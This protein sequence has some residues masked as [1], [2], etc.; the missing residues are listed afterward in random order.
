MTFLVTWAIS[1]SLPVQTH[2][3]LQPQPTGPADTWE[4]V[5]GD[6][7]GLW[8]RPAQS[9]QQA[10]THGTQ[11]QS[12]DLSPAGQGGRSMWPATL[13][14]LSGL[15]EGWPQDYKNQTNLERPHLQ[16]GDSIC[17]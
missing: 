12:Q 9:S 4:T 13:G 17:T 7:D 14:P 10:T 5:A 1:H 15:G 16:D 2:F 3:Q 11:R 8:S 6:T